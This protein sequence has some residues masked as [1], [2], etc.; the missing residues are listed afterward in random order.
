MGEPVNVAVIAVGLVAAA[1]RRFFDEPTAPILGKQIGV[2]SIRT[3]LDT[4][5][6][7][8]DRTVQAVSC[9]AEGSLP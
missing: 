4:G 1:L 6:T 8:R 5:V 7:A 3:V 9:V 2:P